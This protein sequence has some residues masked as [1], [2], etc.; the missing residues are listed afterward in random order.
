MSFRPTITCLS[1][2]KSP[3]IAR[4]SQ[5]PYIKKRLHDPASYRSRS[6]FKLL[7]IDAQWD[8][9]KPNVNTVVDLGAAPGGWSQVSFDPLNI[10]Q[11]TLAEATI[12]RGTIVAVDLLRMEH[13]PGVHRIQA[14]FLSPEADSAIHALLSSKGNLEGKV[15]VILSDMAANTSGNHTRDIETSL[16]ICEAVFEFTQ[17]NIRLAEDVGTKEAVLKHFTHPLLQKF[18]EE[19]LVPNFYNVKYIKPDSSRAA[20]REAYFLC[21]GWKGI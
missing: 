6:A 11:P 14:D 20:S 18:R 21:Q 5:D 2:A 16:E 7:E 9:F 12:G 17:R 8:I 13:I 1:K 10:D 3:W 19:R 4:Q 15:D